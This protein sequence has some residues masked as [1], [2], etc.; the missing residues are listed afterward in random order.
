VLR[1][2]DRL[3]LLF[4]MISYFNDRMGLMHARNVVAWR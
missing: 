1:I 4:A 3:L 2:V